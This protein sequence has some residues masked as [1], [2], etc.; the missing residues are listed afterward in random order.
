MFIGGNGGLYR[1]H[2][3]G[4]NFTSI[5][6]DYGRI[7]GIAVDP[8]SDRIYWSS[9]GNFQIASSL[10]D[11]SGVQTVV[12]LPTGAYTWCLA[13]LNDLIY[14]GD[15]SRGTLQSSTITG[16]DV[17]TLSSE[18]R[19]IQRLILV[20]SSQEQNELWNLKTVSNPCE[21]QGCS[22]ICA[23]KAESYSCMC[24]QGWRLAEDQ[25]TCKVG[26]QM[27]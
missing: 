19:Y 7:V 5:V 25:R 14:W 26:P 16:A 17:T 27:K 24:P 9:Y 3:D 18:T 8:N 12:Q 1:A 13:K 6:T 2:M 21:D 23:L 4:T 15:V 10:R 20:P 22:H 11:G